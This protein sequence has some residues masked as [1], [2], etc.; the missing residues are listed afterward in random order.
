MLTVPAIASKTDFY[1]LERIQPGQTGVA[2]TVFSGTKVERFTV[3]VISLIDGAASRDKMILVRLGGKSLQENGG[4]AA[5]MSGSPVYID[6]KLV[7]AISYGFENA[8]AYL[9]LV[10][11]IETMIKLIPAHMTAETRFHR[12]N[13]WTPVMTPVVISGMGTRGFEL[14]HPV[15]AENGNLRP[16][17]FPFF[18]KQ[19]K[20]TP[21]SGNLQPGE[22]VAVQLVTGDYQVTAVGTVTLVDGNNFLA[23]GHSFSNKG[24]VDYPVFRAYIHQTVKSPLLSFKLG[25]ATTPA[26]RIIQD[27]NAGIFGRL[28]EE[29]AMIK[30]KVSVKDIDRREAHAGEFWVVKHEQL[31]KDF[32]TSGVTDAIDRTIDRIGQGTAKVQIKVTIAGRK[33][34]IVRENLFFGKDIALAS[35]KEL[36]TLLDI[37]ASNEFSAVDIES[38]SVNAEVQNRQI[39]ARIIKAEPE[40][41]KVKPGEVFTVNVTLRTF[42]GNPVTVPVELKLPNQVEPGKINISLR[43]GNKSLNGEDDSR[44][45]KDGS[46]FDFKDAGSLTELLQMFG[47]T[48]RNNDLFFE[49]TYTGDK[50]VI[51]NEL[52]GK[53]LQ[54]TVPTDYYLFGETQILLEVMQP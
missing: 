18:Q 30:V 43:S 29:P 15:M 26:G 27:R 31:Y 54:W 12:G 53:A 37:L 17:F 44:N 39:S 21:S 25:S 7:G 6:Q 49:F 5:G 38:V 45:K 4:L 42:R 51:L 35:V 10:T 3:E 1:P 46:R 50:K 36:R 32:I 34:P 11:P 8:D 2:Y 9:A 47:G 41:V 20:E 14:L 22:A 16:V 19:T 13:Q 48:P 52:T 28:G 23:F 24:N 33:E 40:R